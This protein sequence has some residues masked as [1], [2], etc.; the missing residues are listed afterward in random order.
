MFGDQDRYTLFAYDSPGQGR[1]SGRRGDFDLFRQGPA[2]L[3][4]FIETIV[5]RYDIDSL[6]ILGE[7]AGSGVA[8]YSLMEQ[9]IPLDVKGLIFMPGVYR[10]PQLQSRFKRALFN[11]LNLFLPY[12]RLRSKKPFTH[13]AE[14]EHL[15]ELLQKD[16]YYCRFSSIRY[17]HGLYR[18]VKYL[19][20]R[21]ADFS[22]PL[23]IMHGCNDYYSEPAFVE[24]LCNRLPATT[25]RKLA[26]FEKSKHWLTVS[27]E[28]EEIRSCLF[29][30]IKE[31]EDCRNKGKMSFSGNG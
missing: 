10:I 2:L 6:Y 7:S 30:W 3:V 4:H 17:N 21:I 29:R 14:N 23:L 1:S 15:L 31:Q 12:L 27:E 8:F 26:F 18:F 5:A 20:Y 11:M 16:S 22:I 28:R 25:L 24:E 9:F 13:Y 19:N